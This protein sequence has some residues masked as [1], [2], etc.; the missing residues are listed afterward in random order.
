MDGRCGEISPLDLLHQAVWGV[1][2]DGGEG[3]SAGGPAARHLAVTEPAVVGQ[4][5]GLALQCGQPFQ[6]LPD[7]LPLKAGVHCLGDISDRDRGRRQSFGGELRA[8][9]P[10]AGPLDPNPRVITIQ[11]WEESACSVRIT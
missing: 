6:A 3:L 11:I 9:N 1:E 10:S 8:Q 2:V 5:D 4:H 7:V